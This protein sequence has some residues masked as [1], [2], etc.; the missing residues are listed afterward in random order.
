METGGSCLQV[1]AVPTPAVHPWINDSSHLRLRQ[2]TTLLLKPP[3]SQTTITNL[4]GGVCSV[5]KRLLGD[6]S[7]KAGGKAHMEKNECSPVRLVS[8]F[9]MAQ[10]NVKLC[11]R[12][13]RLICINY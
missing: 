9:I 13:F 12:L 11:N 10:S 4:G 1:P 5:H 2:P 7:G 8:Q 3:P 6:V